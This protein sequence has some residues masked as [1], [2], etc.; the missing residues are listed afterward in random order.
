M[1]SVFSKL[2]LNVLHM[3][4]EQREAREDEDDNE[5]S[6]IEEDLAAPRKVSH[7]VID[8]LLQVGADPTKADENGLSP[9]PICMSELKL[10]PRDG[11]CTGDDFRGFPR[12]WPCGDFSG[13]TRE[14]DRPA[15]IT[16]HITS[17]YLC[18]LYPL[19]LLF[20]IFSKINCWGC[21]RVS[22]IPVDKDPTLVGK[23]ALTFLD[24]FRQHSVAHF[25][26]KQH[27]GIWPGGQ[28]VAGTGC[29]AVRT[30]S[31]E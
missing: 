15:R 11:I 18:S 21:L 12:R 24:I 13:E 27:G 14:F 20:Y 16:E 6:D 26:L 3:A 10:D 5:E 31:Q 1:L 8:K 7:F 4:C 22:E 2:G 9:P 28:V 23:L 30:Q 17:V 19:F 29:P 25:A